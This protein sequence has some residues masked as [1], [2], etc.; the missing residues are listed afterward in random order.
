[1]TISDDPHT[2]TGAYVT[3][4]LDDDERAAVERHLAGCESCAQEV[5]EL[6]ETAARLGLAKAAAPRRA[7]KDDV[8]A[9]IAT[10]RQEVPRP[11]TRTEPGAAPQRTRRATRWALAACIAAAAVFGG[12]AVWQHQR[13][14]D[15]RAAAERSREQVQELAAVLAAPDAKARTGRL[16]DGASGTVVVSAERDR[17][18]FVATDLPKP[19]R[20]KVY[21]LWFNDAGS[22]RPAGLLDPGKDTEAMLMDGSVGRASGMGITVEP[23]GG[24]PKPTSDPVAL[25]D[26]P[27]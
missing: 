23:E 19:P 7:M 17:A 20:G 2:L 6:G 16:A 15:A 8:L 26:F 13:A 27:A 14:E 5:R 4:A 25:M 22:M 9:R 12:G 11:T 10:V 1:M 21:Q 24:S 18:A 3:H